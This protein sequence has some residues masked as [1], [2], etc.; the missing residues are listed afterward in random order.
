MRV[1]STVANRT[2]PPIHR[3]AK[4][5]PRKVT[6]HSSILPERSVTGNMVATVSVMTTA[7]AAG[8]L[9]TMV[10]MLVT[11]T[12]ANATPSTTG[13]T[14]DDSSISNLLEH[15]SLLYKNTYVVYGNGR[16]S[17]RDLPECASSEEAC[18]LAHSR[19]WLTPITERL[20]RC[21]DRFECPLHFTGLNDTLSQH[22]SNR[23]QLK[24]CGKVMEKSAKCREGE[25]A[26]KV[27]YVERQS[28]PFPSSTTWEGI[29]THTT[30][31]CRCP[32]PNSWTLAD[33][34]I[35]S[36]KET[37]YSYTCDQ[38]PRCNTGDECGYIRA[39]TLASYYLC[40]C[41]V[42]HRCIFRG[43]QPTQII[44][45][46]HFHGPAYTGKCTPN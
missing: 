29:D 22:V 42:Q 40:S 33:T 26:L 46:L 6:P 17:E 23:A 43:P 1:N 24:F 16:R 7:S 32:W 36:P 44:T 27:H 5:H 37:I 39:D 18:N 19:F 20:C 38:L 12:E 10:L 11:T 3:G 45:K 13:Q 31:M 25:I 35:P 21:S 14:E 2:L 8:M 9:L 15:L 30:I 4:I 41:P 28:Q 34:Q